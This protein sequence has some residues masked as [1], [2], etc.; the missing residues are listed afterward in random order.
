MIEDTKRIQIAKYVATTSEVLNLEDVSSWFEE[1]GFKPKSMITIPVYN[2]Q[3][4]VIGVAQ[5][6]NKVSGQQFD[7][8]DISITE[9]FAI[10]CGIG[11][12]NTK[13]Y[14]SAAKLTAKQSVALDCL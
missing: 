8:D 9:A 11:I 1:D 4:T 6:I 7:A 2:G 10:F 5:L 14:E 12:H 3:R 13:T